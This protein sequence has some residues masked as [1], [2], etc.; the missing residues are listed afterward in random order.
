MLYDLVTTK[1]P[2]KLDYNMNIKWKVSIV[3]LDKV[4]KIFKSAFDMFCEIGYVL[5]CKKLKS[6]K[7]YLPLIGIS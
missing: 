4:H 5:H 6:N 3:Q 7:R 1:V 2:P